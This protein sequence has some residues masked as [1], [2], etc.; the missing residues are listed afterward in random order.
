MFH[1][2]FLLHWPDYLASTCP[3]I[4]FQLQSK[5]A[6]FLGDMGVIQQFVNLCLHSHALK[7]A[8]IKTRGKEIYLSLVSLEIPFIL[9]S[10]SFPMVLEKRQIC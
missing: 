1:K 2:Q 8:E 7:R 9:F 10:R 5:G 6:D 4:H 3:P